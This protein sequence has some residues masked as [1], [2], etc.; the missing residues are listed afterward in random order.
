MVKLPS[1]L[2][3]FSPPTLTMPLCSH[4]RA[5]GWPLAA[6]DWA[7]SFSWWGKIRSAP[8]RWMSI[9]V[10]SS[11]RT[12]AEHSMCQ[13]GRPA[14]QG[15]GKLG[16]PGLAPFQSA[17]SNGWRLRASSASLVR[18]LAPSCC[19]SSVRPLSLP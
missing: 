1:D 5:R 18:P 2:D 3:I 15:E 17:K 8:P 10:P 14:P 16:S 12:M 6:S 7:I 19:S 9:V 4:Q 13:P 11:S